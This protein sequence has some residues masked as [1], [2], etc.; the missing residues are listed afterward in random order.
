MNNDN[1]HNSINS[2]RKK[3]I[4]ITQNKS[5]NNITIK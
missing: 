2:N 1:N 4:K 3:N 5:K